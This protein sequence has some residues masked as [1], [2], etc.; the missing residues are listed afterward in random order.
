MSRM[1][2]PLH[3]SLGLCAAAVLA[4]GCAGGTRYIH[5]TKVPDSPQNRTLLGVVEQ[6]RLALERKDTQALIG[7][8]SKDYWEDGG[9]PTGSDDY[10]YDGLR[11]VLDTRFARADGIRYSM[12]YMDVKKLEGNRAA[13]EVLIDASYSIDTANG[14]QRRD[15]RDQNQLVLQWDG[16]SWKFLS[17]M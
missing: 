4:A 16:S 15:M 6:Y 17:G 9:T 5:G 7:L 14:K 3:S 11:E 13:V 2:R 12:R 1:I 8:A 10:G